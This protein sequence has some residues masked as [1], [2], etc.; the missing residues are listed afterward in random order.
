MKTLGQGL[1][2]MLLGAWG[3]GVWG[4]APPVALDADHIYK[5]LYDLDD[6]IF[7]VRDRADRALR[8]LGSGVMPYLEDE[9]HR[10]PSLE[11]RDR[12]RRMMRD[13]RQP[14]PLCHSKTR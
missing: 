2:L 7:E 3:G 10:N 14:V 13:L 6:D 1:L 11:V 8:Q 5:C 4:A 9:Y 12:L